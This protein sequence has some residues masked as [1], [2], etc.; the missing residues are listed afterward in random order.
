MHSLNSDLNCY[1]P[2]NFNREPCIE[3]F[4]S[5]LCLYINVLLPN[6]RFIAPASN[7]FMEFTLSVCP[8]TV[9]G[10]LPNFWTNLPI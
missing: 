8:S 10:I 7:N 5:I 9:G 3:Y 6:K 1:L 2:H 4:I